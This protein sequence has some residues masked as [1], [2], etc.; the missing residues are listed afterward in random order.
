MYSKPR[1]IFSRYRGPAMQIGGGPTS[2]SLRDER[3][4]QAVTNAEGAWAR[5]A[6]KVERIAR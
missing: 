6:G 2:A 4:D 1:N 3:N 5:R